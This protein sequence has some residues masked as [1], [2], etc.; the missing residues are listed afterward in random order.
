[1]PRIRSTPLRWLA[2]IVMGVL[3][4]AVGFLVYAFLRGGGSIDERLE[5]DGFAVEH[6]SA[7]SVGAVGW[8][9]FATHERE[10]RIAAIESGIGNAFSLWGFDSPVSTGAPIAEPITRFGNGNG[11]IPVYLLEWRGEEVSPLI[12]VVT[13]S[14]EPIG[15]I[16]E[17]AAVVFNPE[18]GALFGLDGWDDDTGPSVIYVP[19]EEFDYLLRYGLG[20]WM[21]YLWCGQHEMPSGRLPDLLLGGIADYTASAYAPLLNWEVEVSFRAGQ[22]ELTMDPQGTALARR[23]LGVSLVAYLIEAEGKEGFLDSLADW[24]RDSD[25][26]LEQHRDGW[27]AYLE[28]L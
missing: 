19:L 23:V 14:P 26:M 20:L 28:S 17:G 16:W 22:R 25:G 7:T 8:V 27:R 3:L 10:E 12:T 6:W 24:I 18:M 2:R 11:T 21:T 15:A 1:M 4:L 9:G 5:S 13:A